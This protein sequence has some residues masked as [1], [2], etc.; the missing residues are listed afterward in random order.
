MKVALEKLKI[1]LSIYPRSGLSEFNIGRLVA[2]IKTG[3]KLPPIVVESVTFRIV[4]GRHRTVA[5][6]RMEHKSIEVTA[7]SYKSEADL[8][9]DAVRLNVGH[10]QPLDQYNIRSA[11]I[12]LTEYGYTREKISDIV[13]LPPEQITKIERGFA[14][15]STT[16]RPIALKGGLSHL[17]GQKLEESQQK[18]NR[19]Y[20]GPK[21]TFYLRQLCELL[22]NDMWPQT[23]VFAQEMDRLCELWGKIKSKKD[24]EAA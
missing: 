12:R 6:E 2:A 1:D 5:H 21:A 24:G 3:A 4:D 15:D 23:T 11:I 22:L 18:V 8:F 16:G 13:R 7:K 9:A 10:G 19:Q 20:G 14:S 17:A